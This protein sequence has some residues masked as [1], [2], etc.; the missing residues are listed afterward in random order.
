MTW[1]PADRIT[2]LKL[3]VSQCCNIH[4]AYYYYPSKKFCVGVKPR[5][6]E[7]ESIH[8]VVCYCILF[9]TT[10]VSYKIKIRTT[11][12]SPCT[13]VFSWIKI[14]PL[15]HEDWMFWTLFV[16]CPSLLTLTLNIFTL[17]SWI[18]NDGYIIFQFWFKKLIGVSIVIS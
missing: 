7:R 5:R 12:L 10:F 13:I 14:K 18:L 16:T 2:E 8:N 15:N 17:L 11:I 1:V 6:E 4:R 3:L 9:T